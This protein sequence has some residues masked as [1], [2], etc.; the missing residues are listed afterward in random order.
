[1]KQQYVRCRQGF[2]LALIL[3]LLL[4]TA[5][6]AAEN[7]A[8][9]QDHETIQ[10]AA[11]AYLQGV[12]RDHHGEGVEVQ[13][14][15]GRLDP[16]L[17]L[18]A[19][20]EPLQA[21]LPPGARLMGNTTVGVRCGGPAPW[22]LFVPMEV[23]VSG[24]VLVTRRPL[25]RDTVLSGED[26]RLERRALD[27]L[28]GGYLVDPQRVQGMVLRR[29]LQAGTVLTPQLVEPRQLVHRGQKVTLMAQNA[30]ISVRVRGEALGDGAYGEQVRVRNLSSGRVV[31]GRVLS[32]GVVGV[33]M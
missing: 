14:V 18:R 31:E 26:I 30:A 1:M 23:R 17:R 24:E 8:G 22:R 9:I 15:A 13:V 25:P 33:T 32:S 27:D 3:V 19:C 4:P 12:A 10:A 29:S 16:R 11:R 5:G 28:H 21:S 7:A 20:G 6:S 2:F